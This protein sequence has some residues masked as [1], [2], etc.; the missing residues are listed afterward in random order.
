[1][2]GPLF[3]T[4]SI[5][6]DSILHLWLEASAITEVP[7]SY[8][9]VTI[10]SA[11]GC[12]LRRQ[13]WCDQV[14]WKV[15][16]NLSS[17]LIGPS[18]IGKDVAIRAAAR[19][20]DLIDPALDIG[21]KTMEVIVE[22][23]F[24]NGK[25]GRPSCA[26]ILAP[27]LTAFLGGKDYQRSMVQE[28][29]DLL[30]TGDKVNVSLKSHLGLKKIIHQPTITMV[31]GSTEEWLHK[32]MP[33]GSLEGGL[34]PR[35]LIICEEYNNKNVPWIKYSV[36][37]P[38]RD[39]ALLAKETFIEKVRGIVNEF[40]IGREITPTREAIEYYE[41]WYINRFRL[42]SP[43]VRPYANRS[44]DQVLRLAMLCAITRGRHYMDEEDMAFASGVIGYV[45]QTID[46]A[47]LP[48]SQDAK[49]ARLILGVLP[50][51]YP[52]I[53][54]YL[55]R[56]TDRRDISAGL[57]LL[58]ESDQIVKDGKLLVKTPLRREEVLQV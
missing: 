50:A 53:L 45:G 38:I 6:P 54:A 10:L 42:F 2:G 8:S 33:D 52:Q 19:L 13:V 34:F 26:F 5:P 17:L 48:P 23:L 32:A 47:A 28:L 43:V 44:R 57:Q 7:P 39:K 12:L 22:Q 14:D 35:F 4:K 58:L 51:T 49:V 20:I 27:E 15:Y 41:N 30:S 56:N 40:S 36:D 37:K 46:R 3:S 55:S 16:Q 24:E 1:M 29:T 11:M 18:G 21:G 9:V 25:D 31:A